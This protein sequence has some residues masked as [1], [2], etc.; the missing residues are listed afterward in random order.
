MRFI[1]VDVGCTPFVQE[2][3]QVCLVAGL[4]EMI[5]DNSSVLNGV[6]VLYVE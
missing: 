5:Q 3:R 6:L 4:F 1:S 2:M